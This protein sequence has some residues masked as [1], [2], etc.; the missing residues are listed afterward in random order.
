MS[1]FAPISTNELSKEQLNFF[2]AF[3][4]CSDEI[5]QLILQ[6]FREVVFSPDASDDEQFAANLSIADAL[7]P[8]PYNGKHGM[9]LEE[10]ESETASKNPE[11]AVIVAE[12]DSEEIA[13]SAN[14]K[15]IMQERGMTQMQLAEAVGLRQSAIANLI[16]RN[17]R[18]QRRTVDKL[19]S[20]LN[21]KP[22]DLWS[23]VS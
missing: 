15:R 16:G 20:A 19:A 12:M 3:V 18:P 7:F 13:F 17:C 14:L 9:D 4:E 1:T 11:L 22:V 23:V 5:Q 2:R 6:L 10:S 21:V 8:N